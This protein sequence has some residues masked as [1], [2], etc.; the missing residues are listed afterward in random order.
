MKAIAD[1]VII[2]RLRKRRWTVAMTETNCRFSQVVATSAGEA[3]GRLALIDIGVSD[4]A[5]VR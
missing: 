5:N 4:S 3:A 1:D 2:M